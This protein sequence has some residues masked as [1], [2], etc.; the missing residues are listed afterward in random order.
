MEELARKIS[1]DECVAALDL[2]TNSSRLLIAACDGT[3]VYRDV[4]HVALGEGL[5]ENKCF[6]DKAMERA[7]CSYMDFSEMME[8]YGVKKY[9]A[10]ATAACRMS[11]NTKSFL[12]EIKKVSNIDVDVISE[13]EEARLTLKGAML[14][15]PKDKKYIFVYDLGGGSTEVSLA[16]NE[17]EPKIIAT[18]SIPLGA[19]N[20]TEMYGLRNYF[21]KR[22]CRLRADVGRYMDDFLSKIKDIDYKDNVALVATS[23][24][25]LRLAAAFSKLPKYDKF[26]ADGME[27]KIKDLDELIASMIK[28]NY[29]QRV[30]SVYI[31]PNRAPIFVAALV[32]FK[33]IYDKLEVESMV[34]S[35]KAAQEAIIFE[36]L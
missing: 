4:R 16:T 13:Y 31:G 23:S 25:P 21:H 27:V 6:S 35:L 28:F 30:S 9:R 12:E 15:A 14:N 18:V 2:G 32:I 8:V 10:I 17:E 29:K 26:A 20:A 22:A 36:L 33:A 19:R 11:N 5:A 24:T 3:P 34:A 1:S 7:I